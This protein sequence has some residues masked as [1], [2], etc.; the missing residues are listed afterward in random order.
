ML[1]S[2]TTEL[3]VAIQKLGGFAMEMLEAIGP[4]SSEI[5]DQDRL[6][7]VGALIGMITG[8]SPREF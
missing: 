7:G 8:P 1:C 5:G 6:Q 4:D 3:A 2:S